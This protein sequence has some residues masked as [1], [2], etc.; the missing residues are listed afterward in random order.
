MRANSSSDRMKPRVV[1]R[2]PE[3]PD[4][5]EFIARVLASRALH[6]PW[7]TAPSTQDQ[8]AAYVSRMQEPVN[9]GFVV[10]DAEEGGMV[11]VINITNIVLGAFRSGY[12]S[13]Y[14]FAG[15]ERQGFMRAGLRQV[16]GHAFKSLKLHRLEANIQPGNVASISLVR[17]C[18]FLKEGYSPR[19]LKINGRWC[20][21]ERWAILA[22]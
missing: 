18:G 13:Y 11:G 14:G 22:S 2:P 5:S 19:Y 6:K 3:L 15:F 12:L 17:S 16:V 8:F 1:I 10:C 21:H 9:C 20:D 4:Q 7:V